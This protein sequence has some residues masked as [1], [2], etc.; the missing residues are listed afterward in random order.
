[1]KREVI[2]QVKNMNKYFGQV[3]ALNNVSITVCRGEIQGLIGENG[4]GK[5]TISSIISGMQKADSGEMF[6]R[7]EKW[8][9][10]SMLN[11]LELGVGMIVQENGT[12]PGI[13]V[14][15]NIYLGETKQFQLFGQ[16]NKFGPVRKKLLVKAAQEIL[17]QIGA[18]HIRA[19]VVTGS[20]DLQDRK[21]IEIA[22]VAAKKPEVLIVDETTTALS[23]VGRDILYKIMADMQREKKAVIFITHDLDE[24]MSVCNSLSV[25]RDG[26]MIVTFDKSEFDEDRIKISMIGRELEGDY[27][28]SDY[29]GSYEQDIVLE[30]K[31]V[32]LG[33]QVKD[34]SLALHKGEIL[35]IGGLSHCG[36]HTLG[37][38]LFG[39]LKPSE[40]EVLIHGMKM[41]NESAAMQQKVGYVA[42]DRDVESLCLNA[43]IK[44]NIAV[45]G[46]E[47]IALGKCLVLPNMETRYVEKQIT[48]LQIKCIHMNQYVS[49]LS[50]GNKQ[51]VVFG[52]WIG[53]GSDI[54]VL[55]CPTRGVDIGVKQAMYQL[56]YQMKKEGKSIVIISEEMTELIGM[57]DRL[58]VMKDGKIMKEFERSQT[59]NEADIIKYMI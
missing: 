18:S 24:I 21:L 45:G 17:D 58:I 51:K 43:S 13:T 4:S 25:L 57:S 29:D 39:A 49:T 3:T 47:Q 50:G 2:V 56:L 44:D 14:A 12:V 33:N 52:K 16:R 23:Q 19:D 36:M 35:G 54:L 22:K 28:R 59:L 32:H 34:V 53:R 20:L 27:Y 26:R 6:Y 37:K 9:P 55:D 41:K 30:M 1:M 40:G 46:L 38:L 48:D 15:E 10:L 7:G 31:D 42:K 5:S 11:A 8:N